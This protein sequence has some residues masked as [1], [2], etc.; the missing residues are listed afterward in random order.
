MLN[1]EIPKCAACESLKGHCRPDKIKIAKK[2]PMKEKYL[3]KYHIIPGHM[4]SEGHY[5]LMYTG[6]IYY[7]KVKSDPSEMLSGR[8]IFIDHASGYIS[9]N[10]QVD[11]NATETVKD[12]I[13]FEREDQSQ[14]VVI[15]G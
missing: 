7:K 13:I 5:I 8:C 2:H 6:I 1:F 10:N 15:R 4:V 12:K 3:K 9:I 14:G 11:I